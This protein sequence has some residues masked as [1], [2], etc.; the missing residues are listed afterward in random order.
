[1]SATEAST[2]SLYQMDIDPQD[3]LSTYVCHACDFYYVAPYQG[4]DKN[5]PSCNKEKTVK[6]NITTQHRN[7]NKDENDMSCFK[8]YNLRMDGP[9]YGA[10]QVFKC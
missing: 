4:E 9:T 6:T 3:V 7:K 5:C 10:I 8:H 1:M 2:F